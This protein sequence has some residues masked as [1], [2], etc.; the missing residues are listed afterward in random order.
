[1]SRDDETGCGGTVGNGWQHYSTGD[2]KTRYSSRDELD[3]CRD[4]RL[5]GLAPRS[6]DWLIRA[7]DIMWERTWGG[8]AGVAYRVP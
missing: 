2:I 8:V 3:A 1:M 7:P 5:T 6:R 4:F